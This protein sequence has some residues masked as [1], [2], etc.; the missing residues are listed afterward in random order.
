MMT[1]G[2]FRVVAGGA[3]LPGSLTSVPDLVYVGQERRAERRRSVRNDE[4]EKLLGHFGLDRRHVS[5]R[6]RA[7]SSW[8]LLSETMYDKAASL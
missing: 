3:G 8:L 5:D 7:D 6:R 2:V 1:N 4:F